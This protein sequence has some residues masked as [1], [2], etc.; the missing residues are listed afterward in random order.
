MQQAVLI[1]IPT[2]VKVVEMESF[3]K[4]AKAMGMTKSAVSKQI[5]AL[6]DALTVRLLNRTTRS[7]RLTDEGEHFYQQARQVVEAVGEAERSVQRLNQNPSGVLKITAPESFGHYH[8][9]SALAEFAATYPDITLEAEFTNRFANILEEGIDVA[10]RIASLT[11]SSLIARKLARCQMVLAAA[12]A[13][14]ERCGT[15][16]HP[17]QLIN[18]RFIENSYADRP[19]E[20]RYKDPVGK[21]GVAPIHVVMRTNAGEMFREAARAGIGIVAAPSFMLGGDIKAGKLVQVLAEFAAEPERNIY[22]LF[23]HN[24]HM[25]AKVRLFVDFIAKR[26]AGTPCWEVGI[27]T[28][29]CSIVSSAWLKA[30]A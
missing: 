2:F 12:P 5:Q 18:H 16:T 21:M 19:K 9:A 13:Y 26:F 11:D 3:S 4:A 1:Y 14:L 7:V 23:P 30:S 8:L 25:S 15:P 6:E 22:A 27:E 10:I 24:R 17:D 28:E 20:W 29:A